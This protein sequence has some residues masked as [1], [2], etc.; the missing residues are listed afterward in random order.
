MAFVHSVG[1]KIQ[2][3][4]TISKIKDAIAIEEK[5]A[6]NAYYEIGKLYYQKHASD[7]E[8]D[9]FAMITAI[10]ESESKIVEYKKQILYINGLMLCEHCGAEIPNDASFCSA[11]GAATG[12][13]GTPETATAQCPNCGGPIAAGDGF[14]TKCGTKI[15]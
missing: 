7:C 10:R 14:C 12:V 9:F 11:C 13:N 4:S 5:L 8:A 3:M 6:K 15:V 2:N 1:Q